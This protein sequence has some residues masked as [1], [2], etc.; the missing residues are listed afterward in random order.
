MDAFEGEV[1]WKEIDIQRTQSCTK[2]SDGYCHEC[3]MVAHR[4]APDSC[5]DKL[6]HERCEADQED[7]GEDLFHKSDTRV[8]KPPPI[9]WSRYLSINDGADKGTREPPDLR[10]RNQSDSKTKFNRSCQNLNGYS[11]LAFRETRLG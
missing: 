2:Y 10:L 11:I 7:T 5:Q 1:F 6:Q 8:H 9:S 3:E 4:E